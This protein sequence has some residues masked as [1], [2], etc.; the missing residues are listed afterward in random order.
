M[1]SS[2][3]AFAREEYRGDLGILSWEIRS[4]NHRYLEMFLRLPEELRVL[5]PMIREHINARLGRGKLDVS[6]KFK[7]GGVAEAGLSV[8]QRMV[9]QLVNAERQIADLTGL[10]ESLRSGDLLRWPGVLEEN[11]QD[12]TPVKQQAMALLETT[13]DSLIDNRLREGDRLGEIIRQRCGSLKLQVE[14]VRDLMPEVLDGFRNRIS[15]RLSEVLDEMD[16]TRLEQEMVILAQRLDV[17]EEMDRLETHLDEVE[18]VLAA[19][20]PIGRRLDFLMQELNR[21]ANTLTSKSTS[22][23][24]TRAAVEMKVLI[25]Q[26]REQIQNIE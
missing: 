21:E 3:T 25:E 19:D 10:N 15:E 6:L 2:M 9:H 7:P 20:E 16:E 4:V 1:I 18:R 12:L 13:I 8:N 11:E 5:E 22:V 26:M 24:V 23:D 17:D 14:Q